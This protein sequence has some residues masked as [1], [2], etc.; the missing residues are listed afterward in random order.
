MLRQEFA[1]L[2]NE[3]ELTFGVPPTSVWLTEA[4]HDELAQ[5]V[6]HLPNGRSLSSYMGVVIHR[7]IGSRAD[8]AHLDY[9][10]GRSNP[11]F[12]R[13]GGT[14]RVHV[15]LAG[16]ES[17]RAEIVEEAVVRTTALG[18]NHLITVLLQEIACHVRET[19][20]D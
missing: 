13:G 12:S 4:E 6:A 5:N 15:Q 8:M 14:L 9:V 19:V 16:L 10:I 7:V 17:L 1:E 3:F 2:V 20:P 11:T 18:V